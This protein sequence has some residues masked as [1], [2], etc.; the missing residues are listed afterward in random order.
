VTLLAGGVLPL[1]LCLLLVLGLIRLGVGLVP[2]DELLA[3]Y[4]RYR[5][6]PA[7]APPAV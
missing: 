7:Q 6:V 4:P 1:L 3:A 2:A 5:L